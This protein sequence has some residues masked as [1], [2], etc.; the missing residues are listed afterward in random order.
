MTLVNLTLMCKDIDQKDDFV[1]MFITT[2]G[3]PVALRDEH[4]LCPGLPASGAH[5][6]KKVVIDAEYTLAG[7]DK[8]YEGDIVRV[9]FKRYATRAE[10]AA[11]CNRSLI[12][13]NG[14]V[15]MPRSTPHPL[16]FL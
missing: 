5:M 9:L 16:P 6:D 4:G 1:L 3:N 7:R 15:T 12:D 2:D 11:H 13:P 14:H 10:Y 8:S